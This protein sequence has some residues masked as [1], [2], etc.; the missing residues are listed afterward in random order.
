MLEIERTRFKA[1]LLQKASHLFRRRQP[2][3]VRVDKILPPRNLLA[4]CANS[5]L[6]P[7]ANELPFDSRQIRGVNHSPA[8][9]P[10]D[11]KHL[12]ED[13]L[14]D[15]IRGVLNEN[16]EEVVGKWNF[17][18]VTAH[19]VQVDAA[20]K[21]RGFPSDGEGN[22][23]AVEADRR[24]ASF[25]GMKRK[26]SRR[27]AKVENSLSF[28]DLEGPENAFDTAGSPFSFGLETALSDFPKFLPSQRHGG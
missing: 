5:V 1:D 27:T 8:R 12:L 24:G 7:F 21:L 19:A 20:D 22:G 9:R 17:Q 4:A 25:Q 14:L 16:I 3:V 26:G 18:R 2:E 13:A 23:V 28:L 11:T 6:H 15:R 10:Q